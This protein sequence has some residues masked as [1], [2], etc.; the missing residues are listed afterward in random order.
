MKRTLSIIAAMLVAAM[1]YSQTPELRPEVFDLIDRDRSGMEN[2]KVLHQNG[3]DA[4]AAAALLDYYRGRKGIVTATIRDLSKVK[5]SPEEKKWADEGLEHTFFVHYGYQPSYNY[6]EDINWKFWP[7]KDME[8]RW[9]LHRHKWWVPMGQAYKVTKDEKYA[10]EW[11][12][13]YID[14]IIKNPYDDPDK[15]NLRFS[16]RPLEVSDRLRKQPDMFMLFVDSPAFTPEFLTEFLVNYH[17]HAE[18]I[19][20][21]YSEHGNHLLFQAQRMIGAG[22]F[23]PEFKRAKTWSDSGVG[24]LNREINLQVFEDGGHYEL[25]PH[26]HLATINIFLEALETAD[27]NG[28]RDLFPQNYIDKVESMIMYYGNLCFPDYEN[29]C[30]SD[31]KTIHKD[32]MLRNYRRWSKVFPENEA[33]KYWATEGKS[34]KLPEYLS[35][36]YLNTGTFIFRNSWGDDAT[37][38]VV[39]AGPPAFWHNQPD[40][41][42]FELWYKGHNLFPDSGAYIYSGD[43]EIMKWR[44]W[45]RRTDSHNTI[46]LDN[47]DI[48]NTDSKTLLWD[49]EAS[50]PVLV[51]ENQGYEGF[52]HRRSIFF[53]DRKWFVIVD[54]AHGTASGTVNLN[55]QMPMGE[56][57]FNTSNMTAATDFKDGSNM[58]LKCFAPENTEMAISDGWHSP[59]YRTKVE[60][61]K[62]SFNT[63]KAEGEVTRYI[64]VIVPKDEPGDDLK[65]TASFISK[66]FNQNSLSIQVK[67]GKDR[68]QKLSYELK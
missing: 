48:D 54:E 24:I 66:A 32:E 64:T 20:A 50:T 10:V 61:K 44:R 67:V 15:E 34:G 51:T 4:E 46:T 6:G 68:K 9:Q 59:A 17:K 47:K 41:G 63:T 57:V 22:C 55:Y 3:Q 28:L 56:I 40:N 11:T 38:M 18:H 35:K 5:I 33:I 8:L 62:I 13:Q 7:V 30:F 60:R 58:I 42:T 1:A 14:W 43:D 31:A 19:L 2:V 23:F 52:S 27:I 12:K 37:Q 65:I 25:C 53:V 21:N 45:F 29:P 49:A 39:K 36:G 16:W 26:Y